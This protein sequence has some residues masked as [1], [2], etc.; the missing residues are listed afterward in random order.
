VGQVVG[1]GADA[2]LAHLDR[3]L[4]GADPWRLLQPWLGH[5]AI[6]V[7]LDR[8][9]ALW[10]PLLVPAI[11]WFCWYPERAERRRFLLA[12]SLTWIGLAIILALALP[13]A[14]PCYYSSVTG[15]G[16]PFGDLMAYLGRVNATSGL[17]AL[18][19]QRVALVGAGERSGHPLRQH[20]CNAEPPCRVPGA[21]H[22]G[23][24][25]AVAVVRGRVAVFAIL[26]WLGSI[27]LG[28]HY[29]I[30]GEVAAVAVVGIWAATARYGTLKPAS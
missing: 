26:T 25:A 15:D 20:C 1:F 28:W 11:A 27:H 30:D 2:S 6:T 3:T 21:L 7:V 16:G 23:C 24:L 5:P 29:A 12:V 8:L 10:L 18:G 4:H 19:L 17:A 22:V 13:S 9:Y 14:G